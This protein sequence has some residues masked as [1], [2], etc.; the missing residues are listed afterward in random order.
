MMLIFIYIFC[1]DHIGEYLINVV[2]FLRTIHK[3][4]YV[5][6]NVLYIY[7]YIIYMCVFVCVFVMSTYII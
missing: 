2:K 3:M 4:S 5:I 6:Y 7:S 1:V